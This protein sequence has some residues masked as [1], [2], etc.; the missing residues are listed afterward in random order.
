MVK[1]ICSYILE[2]RDGTY[3]VGSTNNWE[4]R[5]HDHNTGQNRYTKFR[6]PVK[7]VYR[8]EFSDLKEA[9]SYEYF[10]KRQRNKEFYKKLIDRAPVV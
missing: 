1:I 3:Y 2:C 4:R 5:W 6:L 9:R 7:L 8:K 10:I